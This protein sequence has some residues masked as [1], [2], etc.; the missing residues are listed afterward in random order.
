M[1]A[2]LRASAGASV[3]VLRWL[4]RALRRVLV[5][6]DAPAAAAAPAALTLRQWLDAHE[7]RMDT[8]HRAQALEQALER[9]RRARNPGPSLAR[10]LA[11]WRVPPRKPERRQ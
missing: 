10:S 1:S 7:Q 5:R 2:L 9:R 3:T 4:S 6:R 11:W 8:E